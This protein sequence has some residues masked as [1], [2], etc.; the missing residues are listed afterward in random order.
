MQLNP[1]LPFELHEPYVIFVEY[2]MYL[3]WFIFYYLDKNLG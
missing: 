2:E 3:R 1:C